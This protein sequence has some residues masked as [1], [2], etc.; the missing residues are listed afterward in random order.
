M[1][2]A[3]HP[4]TEQDI[5]EAATVYESE[6]TPTVAARFIGELKRIATLFLE[7][8][9]IGSPCSNGPHSWPKVSTL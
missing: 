6:G 2:A 7:H 9:E 4:A 5:P 8:P 3:L 1:K